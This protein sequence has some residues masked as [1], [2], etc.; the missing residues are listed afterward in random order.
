MVS[1]QLEDS[2]VGTFFLGKNPINSFTSYA[3]NKGLQAA[4]FLK[5]LDPMIYG[6]MKD[7]REFGTVFLT[8]CPSGALSIATVSCIS[9]VLE[10]PPEPKIDYGDNYHATYMNEAVL[11]LAVTHDE[12]GLL[13]V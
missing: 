6:I 2:W 8:S 13:A 12:L 9:T 4:K 1:S 3:E 11:M 5:E 10:T 7:P